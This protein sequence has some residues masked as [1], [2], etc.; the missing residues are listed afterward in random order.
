MTR[1]NLNETAPEIY[2]AFA[3]VETVIRKGSLDPAVRELV[4]IRASQMNGCLFCIDMHVHE[5]LELGES[6]DRVY[7]LT[8]WRESSLYSGAE[9]A[10]L[11]YAEAVTELPSGVSDEV[12][13]AVTAAFKEDEAAYLVAQM[14]MINSWNRMAAPM[15]T[16]P[17][18]RG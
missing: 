17:P 4:K 14:A 3:H 12:W 9:R 16:P 8:A 15:H 18:N 11:A 10:A 6:P 5:A 1:L 7:Q 13:D 2:K